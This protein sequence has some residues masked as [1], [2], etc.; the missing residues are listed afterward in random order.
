MNSKLLIGI[1]AVIIILLIGI[2]AKVFMGSPSTSSSVESATGQAA[3]GAE[4]ASVKNFAL[5][6][7]DSGSMAESVSGSSK[8]SLAKTAADKFIAGLTDSARL[9]IVVYGHKGDNSQ[10]KK[11]ISCAGI[12]QMYPLG[13]VDVDV[14]QSVVNNLT[15]TGWTPIAASLLKTKQILLDAG[16]YESTVIL[17][18]DGEETCG[19]DPIAAA[20]AIC[21]A[22]MKVDVIGLG[23]NSTQE[24]ELRAIAAAGCGTYYAANNSSQIQDAFIKAGGGSIDTS[25][26]NANVNIYGNVNS[27]GDNG[28]ANI[29]GSD[30]TINAADGR[31]VQT[32]PD[33]SYNLDNGEGV[34][35][36][37]P[38]GTY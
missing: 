36:T 7:D 21:D 16:D 19:G 5:I 4:A 12:E 1:G 24:A 35:V 33:G 25:S 14:A 22:G 3:E 6:L 29:N 17:L 10:A 2:G 31:S 15:P 23:V 27:A 37:V 9:G 18:S 11:A 26:F 28:S 20:K 13:R 32:N 30:A 38:A 34:Q 8:I